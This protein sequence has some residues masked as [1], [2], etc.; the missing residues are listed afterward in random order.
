MERNDEMNINAQ[1]LAKGKKQRKKLSSSVPAQ[2]YLLLGMPLIG[3]F[4]FTIWPIIWSVSKAWFYYDRI[5]LNTKFVGFENFI[6]VFHDTKY[7]Y[8]WLVTIKFTLIKV[9]IEIALSL[10]L[11]TLLA[12]RLKG[13]GFFRTMY[14]LPNI[15]SVAVVGVMFSNI[16]Q[17]FGVA[18]AYLVKWNIISENIDWFATT[19]GAMFVI[20]LS[21][22][23]N[24]FGI[25]VLYF[26][27]ALNNIPKELYEAA[28]I[29]GAVGMQKFFHVTVPMIAPIFQTILL[30][31]I[32]GTLQT[33]DFI[34]AMTNGAPGGST[35]TVAAYLISAFMPGFATDRVNV[36]YGC[37]VGIINSIVYACI[38]FGY[39]K[40]SKKMNE[41]Y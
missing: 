26:S 30:L 39:M 31:S 4:V 12:K 29:D 25:N 37:A 22:V 16:F 23:W 8:S 3:F 34:L 9:P 21:S 28:D 11:A 6:R 18:N 1:A 10:I 7:W 5:P 27:A 35:Y 19:G 17:Y 15:V 38:A 13:S 2:C 32:T 41:V 36:G 14:F 20:V 40:L 24:T 33:G